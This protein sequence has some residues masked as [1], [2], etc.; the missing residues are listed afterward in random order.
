MRKALGQNGEI[1]EYIETIP[2]VGY[3]FV[4]EVRD[5]IA[6]PAPL[7]VERH[8]LSQTTIE[9]EV[10]DDEP[11]RKTDVVVVQPRFT[12]RLP[13]TLSHTARTWLLSLATLSALAMY[14]TPKAI[15]RR[16]P[17]IPTVT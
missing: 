10:I 3:R 2:R 7:I 11:E 9:E 16:P 8:T 17:S 14:Q 15:N 5:V 13:L 12:E 6:Q 4:A 1:A